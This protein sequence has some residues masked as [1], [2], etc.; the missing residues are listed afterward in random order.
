MSPD[1]R[2]Y[3]RTPD[4]LA[5]LAI[6]ATAGLVQIITGAYPG[7]V[8]RLVDQTWAGVW[9]WSLLVSA[10]LA[11][12]G[13]VIRD[14]VD[15]WVLELSGR[16]GVTLTTAAYT[17]AL[18]TQASN[19]LRSALVIGFTAAL[20]VSSGWRTWQLVRRLRQWWG[21]VHPEEG[22]RP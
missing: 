3:A 18:V 19:P 10:L 15:G 6:A 12:L 16:T 2:R 22:A 21:A 5:L 14:E 7:T 4:T 1:R 17:Y 8:L 9:A 13:V 11:L 20:A